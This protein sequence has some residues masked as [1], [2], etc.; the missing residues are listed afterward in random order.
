MLSALSTAKCVGFSGSRSPGGVIP[1]SVLSAAAAAVPA[2]SRVVVGCAGGVDA[3]FR[4]CF[5]AAEVFSVASGQFGSGR[6]AFA[7]RSVACVDAIAQAGGLWVSFPASVCPAGLFPSASS[8][9][10]FSGS[11]SGSW[12]SLAFALGRGVPCLVFSPCGVPAGWG[13]SAVPGCPGWF[14]CDRVLGF[15]VPVQLSLF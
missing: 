11:G 4:Q 1:V 10:C 7:R 15:S 2:G 3:F 14:G 6:S 13:L 12:A 9:R 8:S 5:R